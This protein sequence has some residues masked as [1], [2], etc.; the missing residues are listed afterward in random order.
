M[1]TIQES[2][3][4]VLKALADYADKDDTSGFIEINGD[5]LK[6]ITGL[7]PRQINDA[8]AILVEN[9]YADTYS[10]METGPYDFAGVWIAPRGRY[11]LERAIS[12][13]SQKDDQLNQPNLSLPPVPVGSPFGFTELDWEI[14]SERKSKHDMLYVVL[15]YQFESDH[16]GSEELCSNIEAMFRQ[17]VE[18]YNQR[19]TTQQTIQLEFRP[20]SAGYG[21]HLFNEIARDI[22]GADIAV[23]ETSDQN[24]NVMIEMGVALTWGVR[25]LPVKVEGT[26][27]PPSDISG[28]T[29][30]DYCDSASRFVS[31]DHSRSLLI[32]VQRAAQR[33]GS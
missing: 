11:E 26:D 14:V 9:G 17:A 1:P 3:G 16:Y 29:W 12:A 6:E 25:V 7:T 15:G 30:A 2:L 31:Q 21:E 18:E 33:K 13:A 4:I 27:R 20:L 23:F 5:N 24:P 32:M 22:I 10:V 28:Q 8:V 19:P